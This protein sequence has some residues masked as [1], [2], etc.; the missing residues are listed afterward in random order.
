MTMA[1][2]VHS[3][4][5]V[6]VKDSKWLKL[7]SFHLPS[8]SSSSSSSSLCGPASGPEDDEGFTQPAPVKSR[9][10]VL[11]EVRLVVSFIPNCKSNK[12][13]AVSVK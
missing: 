11:F 12:T 6:S 2:S 9:D 4:D 8:D 5:L 7:P 13:T 3:C 10:E 1:T